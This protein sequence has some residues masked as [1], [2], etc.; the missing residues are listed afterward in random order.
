[1]SK[2]DRLNEESLNEFANN[3]TFSLNFKPMEKTPSGLLIAKEA[4]EESS[5]AR[6]FPRNQIQ[7]EEKR[8]QAKELM[9]QLYSVLELH[10]SDAGVKLPDF[11][12]ERKELHRRLWALL[13]ETI[14]GDDC[15]GQWEYT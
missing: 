7:A 6:Q 8:A 3:A 1:M 13:G 5:R 14:L 15:P 4:K 12:P 2:H 9:S 11:D 10:R